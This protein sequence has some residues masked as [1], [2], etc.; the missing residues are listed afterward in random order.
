MSS[1]VE[2]PGTELWHRIRE[3]GSLLLGEGVLEEPALAAKCQARA[4]GFLHKGDFLGDQPGNVHRL[5]R[6][7]AGFPL[8]KRMVAVDIDDVSLGEAFRTWRAE[9]V[10]EDIFTF[11]APS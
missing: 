9:K 8:E 3:L 6:C 2:L 11:L 1:E 10:E 7:F 4:P 5:R